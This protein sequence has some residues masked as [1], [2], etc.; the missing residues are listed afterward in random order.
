M[1]L[2]KDTS[3]AAQTNW[4]GGEPSW[5]HDT[6]RFTLEEDDFDLTPANFVNVGLY[7]QGG[8]LNWHTHGERL[9]AD[10][11]LVRSNIATLIALETSMFT[12]WGNITAEEKTLA[13]QYF[14][15]PEA[16]IINEL[17]TDYDKHAK[18]WI[19]KSRIAR[20]S[21]FNE[22]FFVAFNAYGEAVGKTELKE[23]EKHV[24]DTAYIRGLESQSDDGVDALFD[25]IEARTGTEFENTGWKAN[26][27][28][29]V[30]G[31]TNDEAIQSIMDVLKGGKYK[32]NKE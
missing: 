12:N 6:R 20:D 19:K 30:N 10:Y 31:Q 17:G 16:E 15:I 2:V 8:V 25:Y 21:R 13:A 3:I 7:S 28:T 9:G 26:G 32:T 22:A 5:H 18:K 11:K 29:P 1:I 27:H 23:I 4:E 14:A 24:L